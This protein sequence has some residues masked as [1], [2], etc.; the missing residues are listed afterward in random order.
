MET[1]AMLTSTLKTAEG[2]TAG[3]VCILIGAGFKSAMFFTGCAESELGF[4]SLNQS[5]TEIDLP[6]LCHDRPFARVRH[7]RRPSPEG[8]TGTTPKSRA[9]FARRR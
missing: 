5:A 2:L 8:L 6:A 3:R 1:A 9:S 4:S 7:W